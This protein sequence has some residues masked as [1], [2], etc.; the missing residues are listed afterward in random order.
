M[1][2]WGDGFVDCGGIPTEERL[3]FPE[4]GPYTWPLRVQL[5]ESGTP[6]YGANANMV[7]FSGGWYALDNPKCGGGSYPN[8]GVPAEERKLLI[9][10]VK[11]LCNAVQ[12]KIFFTYTNNGETIAETSGECPD[13]IMPSGTFRGERFQFAV[14]IGRRITI[15]PPDGDP[16]QVECV[17]HCGFPPETE[18]GG[19]TG[20]AS[21]DVEF[22]F[23]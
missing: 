10:G 17:E 2:T 8:F 9:P 20:G 19:G 23:P 6:I 1:T 16:Y 18:C 7:K 5:Y 3:C 14:T 15:S 13:L 21:F 12:G 4:D 11:P 22:T